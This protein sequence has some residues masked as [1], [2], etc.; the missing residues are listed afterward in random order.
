MAEWGVVEWRVG[1][2]EVGRGGVER[3]MKSTHG[4]GGGEEHAGW[5]REW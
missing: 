4:G 3:V 5:R 1:T 2:G